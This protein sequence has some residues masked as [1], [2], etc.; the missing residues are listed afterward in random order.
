MPTVLQ[1][2]RINNFT[3]FAEADLEFCRGLN[4][5]VGENGVGKTHLLKLPYAVMAAMAA[6][7]HDVDSRPTK[8]LL[9]RAIAEKLVNVMRPEGLGRLARRQRGRQRCEVVLN[10]AEK[11]AKVAFSFA[12]KS[13]SE[14]VMG[15]RP[16]AWLPARPVFLPTREL[17]TIYP[18][19]SALYDMRHLEFEE[20]WRDT[21]Q[22]LGSPTLRG[23]RETEAGQLLVP[24]ERLMG[25]RLVLNQNGRFYLRNKQGSIEMPLVAEGVRKLAMLARL[26]ATGSLA[27]QTTLFWDEPESN[28]NPKLIRGVADAVLQLA[29]G[30]VQMFI[31]THNLF[32]LRELEILLAEDSHVKVPSRFFA[33]G[34]DSGGS[35]VSVEQ[36]DS[37]HEVDPLVL[38]D[39]SLDQSDRYLD[40]GVE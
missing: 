25:G 1:R 7:G 20:T 3:V 36:G 33:L 11:G 19:F 29:S 9:K 5:F 24:L 40:L 13:K 14:V 38:L 34:L 12:T 16:A 32:L 31:A 28:L 26:V 21:C 37:V 15:T 6:P 23:R 39:E 4:V 2:L 17:L 30:G 10:Y 35:G 8:S 18:G 27:S 22:L